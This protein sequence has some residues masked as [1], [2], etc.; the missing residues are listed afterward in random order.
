MSLQD[1]SYY[2]SVTGDEG[3]LFSVEFNFCPGAA[4]GRRLSPAQEK[5][6]VREDFSALDALLEKTMPSGAF[7]GRMK[8]TPTLSDSPAGSQV[9]FI[10]SNRLGSHTAK[11]EYR[12]HKTN[13]QAP[14]TVQL[15]LTL[16]HRMNLSFFEKIMALPGLQASEEAQSSMRQMRAVLATKD[17]DHMDPVRFLKESGA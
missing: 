17:R 7:G 6:A 16:G 4:P 1:F 12:L 2:F 14:A 5:E 13:R 3:G 8:K 15:K 9:G 10:Y 11:L